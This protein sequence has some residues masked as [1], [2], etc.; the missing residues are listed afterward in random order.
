MPLQVLGG[1]STGVWWCSRFFDSP[2]KTKGKMTQKLP[3]AR[4]F[5]RFNCGMPTNVGII[6]MPE[7]SVSK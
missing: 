1:L 7:T 3:L 4:V 6:G 5:D 2:A